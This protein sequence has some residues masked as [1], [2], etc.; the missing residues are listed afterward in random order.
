M[1]IIKH[2]FGVILILING[3]FAI[4]LKAQSNN[5]LYVKIAKMHRNLNF[6]NASYDKPATG[7]PGVGCLYI[8]K[9]EDIDM[10]VLKGMIDAKL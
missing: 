6:K 3:F 2:P 5:S 9:L 8:N 10:K 7:C 4:T 1:K